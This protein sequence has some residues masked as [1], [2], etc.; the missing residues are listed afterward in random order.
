MSTF[1][2]TIR[3]LPSDTPEGVRLRSLLKRAR[4]RFDFVAVPVEEVE[5]MPGKAPPSRQDKPAEETPA[6]SQGGVSDATAAD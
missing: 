3:S 5:D 6:R 2:L 4:R 1:R